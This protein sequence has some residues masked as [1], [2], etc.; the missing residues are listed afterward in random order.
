MRKRLSPSLKSVP[1]EELNLP[2][3]THNALRRA[4][5][6]SI[7][8]IWQS[9]E[10]QTI[11]KIHDIGQSSLDGI[12]DKT[13][14]YISSN[15][16]GEH[17]IE[18]QPSPD[19]IQSSTNVHPNPIT[20]P[21]IS[22]ISGISLGALSNYLGQET[23]NNLQSIGINSIAAFDK[24]VRD[25]VDFLSSSNSLV[26]RTTELLKLQVAQ[27]VDR[28]ALSLNCPLEST[29]LGDVLDQD[30][31]IDFDNQSRLHILKRI[32][33]ACSLTHEIKAITAKLTNREKEIFLDYSLH[34]LTLE[35]VG[36]KQPEPVTR[37]RI[38]Q[39]LIQAQTKLRKGLDESLKVYIGS[40][41]EI[42]RGLGESL[43]IEAWKSDLIQK[44][45]L[46][47]SEDKFGS[48]DLFCAMIRNKIAS[49]SMVYL[50]E[51]LVT[52]LKDK[53]SNPIYVLNYL[54]SDTKENIRQIKRIVNYTGGIHVLNAKE[55]LGCK[56]EEVEGILKSQDMIQIIPE[57]FSYSEKSDLDRSTSLYRAGLIMIQSC[58]PL[59][60]DSFC[61]GL[62]RSISRFYKEIA[63]PEVI[64]HVLK[65]FGFKMENDLISYDGKEKVELSDSD[66]ALIRLVKEK[67]NLISFQ[68]IVDYYLAAGFSFATAVSRVMPASPILE[69]VEQGLY[70][71]RGSE[72]TLQDLETAR[73][74]QDEVSQDS[75]VIFG[76][77]RIVRYRVNVGTWALGGVL[78]ISRTL[79]SLP[80]FSE[81]WPVF[82]GQEQTGTAS[83]DELL[84][85][86]LNATF[87]K[88]GVKVGDRV[89]LAIE[90]HKVK[91]IVVRIIKEHNN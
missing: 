43:T 47:D 48:Y 30:S 54:S 50:P 27:L 57:W 60:F 63:P 91:R 67:G 66:I 31:S 11:L 77:D 3:R 52:A 14:S 13:E 16:S 36:N 2:K 84:I 12:I 24:I 25:Y 86:G 33:D 59:S 41:F 35:E 49:Q 51:I 90:Q 44:E 7:Y 34:G 40:S 75:E 76:S 23:I 15:Y 26:D 20:L 88:L 83:K 19:L 42:A 5:V 80:D 55:V 65:N 37:E 82:V 89:E 85:W 53:E 71:F 32:L 58:G 74:K 21:D 6:N 62:R 78:S 70:K 38:R 69:K 29:T 4:G 56:T 17:K 8:D 61:D 79:P 81:G 9:I 72:V 18:P 45:L 39:I 10:N 87:K 68:D 46:V 1:I 64:K 28:G 73:S 22:Q